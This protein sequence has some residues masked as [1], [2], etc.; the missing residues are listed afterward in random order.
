MSIAKESNCQ[1]LCSKSRDALDDTKTR[2]VCMFSF[3]EA[4]SQGQISFKDAVGVCAV[5]VIYYNR[6]HTSGLIPLQTYSRPSSIIECPRSSSYPKI[7]SGSISHQSAFQPIRHFS[8]T[9]CKG[10]CN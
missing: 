1:L 7:S 10:T 2:T 5:M 9:G 3:V 4:F 8:W 6:F